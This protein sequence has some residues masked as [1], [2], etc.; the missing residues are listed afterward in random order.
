VKLLEL[1]RYSLDKQITERSWESMCQ[2]WPTATPN[3]LIPEFYSNFLNI[4]TTT[5]EFDVFLR[6]KMYHISP[7]VVASALKIPRV[8]QP[9]YP[10]I[11]QLVPLRDTMMELFYGKTIA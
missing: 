6:K 9:G 11:G 1:V 3:D 7:D 4:K 5:L 10:Y 8:A 2:D